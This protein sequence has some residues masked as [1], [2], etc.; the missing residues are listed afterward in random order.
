M[1]LISAPSRH[2][3]DWIKCDSCGAV[4]PFGM[5]RVFDGWLH[6]GHACSKDCMEVMLE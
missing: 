3:H 5:A 4:A 6:I 2:E 1:T